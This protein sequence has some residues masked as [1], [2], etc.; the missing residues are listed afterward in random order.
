MLTVRNLVDIS[1]TKLLPFEYKRK[2]GVF[3]AT[4]HINVTPI[5]LPEIARTRLFLQINFR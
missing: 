3:K 1:N 2:H 5:Y 4:Y